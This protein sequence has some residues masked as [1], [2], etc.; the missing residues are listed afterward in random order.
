MRMFKF[1]ARLLAVSTGAV[2][3]LQPAASQG[4]PTK[5]IRIITTDVGNNND[6]YARMIAQGLASRLGQ[7]VIVENRGG[8]GGGIAVERLVKAPPDGYTLMVHGTSIW[9]LPL[10]NRPC[11]ALSLVVTL[12][13][14]KRSP[15]TSISL[16]GDCWRLNSTTARLART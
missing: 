5:P 15:S 1:F 14:R 11:L 13:A 4:Y 7:Q 12:L 2:V 8:A 10:S 3:A 6:C 9:L 16:I